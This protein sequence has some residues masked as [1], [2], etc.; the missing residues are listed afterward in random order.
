MGR[1]ATLDES[2]GNAWRSFLFFPKVVL[3]SYKLCQ[4]NEG[5][6]AIESS[7]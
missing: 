6:D 5:C 1:S 2:D 7:Q 3:I 4:H